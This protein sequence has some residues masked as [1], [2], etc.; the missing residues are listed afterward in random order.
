[1]WSYADTWREEPEAI[2]L[3]RTKG[4]ELGCADIS[5]STAS[6]LSVLAATLGASTVVEV[7]TGAGIGT[8]AL[9]AGMTDD[10]IITS[11][12]IEAE[13]QRVARELLVSLGYDHVRTRLIAGRPLEVLARLTD[14]AYD[15]LFLNADPVEYPAILHHARRLLRDGGMVIFAGVQPTGDHGRDPETLAITE[16]IETIRDADHWL[17]MLLPLGPGILAAVLQD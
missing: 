8:Q 2:R 3:A 12:D 13:N 7:G 6:L 5:P 11:I 4:A 17:P 1:V 10:G 16:V 14:D 9:L 15:I